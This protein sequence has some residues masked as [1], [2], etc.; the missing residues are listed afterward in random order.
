MVK[1]DSSDLLINKNPK[2][3]FAEAIKT[4]RTNLAFSNI[5]K[6]NKFILITSCEPSDGK[7]FISA[8]LAV[9]YSQEN[10][11]VLLIDCDLRKGRQHRIFNVPN[12]SKGGYSTLILRYREEGKRSSRFSDYV[13]ENF[14]FADYIIKTSIPNVDII[15]SGPIPP[16]PTELLASQNN[17]RLLKKIAEVYDVI[18]LDCPPVIGMSDTSIMTKNSDVNLLVV[19]NKKTKVELI[20]AAKRIFQTVNSEIT[21]VILNKVNMKHSTYGGYYGGYYGDDK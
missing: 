19:S 11:K 20:N 17:Q 14:D 12:K 18:I 10:K 15:P 5:D 1:N 8:N 4:V 13:D 3:R 9:A 21:G 6:E 2:S 7:S 16:N